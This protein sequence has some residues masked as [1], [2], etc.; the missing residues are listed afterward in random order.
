M[1]EK[2]DKRI[3]SSKVHSW[4]IPFYLFLCDTAL[5]KWRKDLWNEGNSLGLLILMETP[6]PR[7]GN[8]LLGRRVCKSQKE[9]RYLWEPRVSAL[10]SHN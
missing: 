6:V 8:F 10:L 7:L 3:I 2:K 4:Q 1:K 5:I 9:I